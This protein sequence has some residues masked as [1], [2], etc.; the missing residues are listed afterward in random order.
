MIEYEI[1]S[2]LATMTSLW[3][4]VGQWPDSVFYPWAAEYFDADG[5]T[6]ADGY[7]SCVWTFHGLSQ[8]DVQAVRALCPGKSAEVYIRTRTDDADAFKDFRAI[9]HWPGDAQSERI[10]DG[11]YVALAVKFTRLEL[12]EG[13]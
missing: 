1:G 4:L 11:S 6:Y 2:S 12:I 13:S 9:M 10:W 7:A 3:T 8:A 5:Y